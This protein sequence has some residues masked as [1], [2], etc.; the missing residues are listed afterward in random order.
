M[1]NTL[2]ANIPEM[3]KRPTLQKYKAKIVKQHARRRQKMLL[4]T[5]TKDRM[6]D[7]DPSLYHVVKQ[8]KRREIRA[9]TQI[10]DTDGIMHTTFK[11]IAATFVRRLAQKFGPL[12]VDP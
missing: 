5:H 9:I 10:R 4:D 2:K 8:Q 12:E 7:E 3:E 6:D 1:Y 11:V